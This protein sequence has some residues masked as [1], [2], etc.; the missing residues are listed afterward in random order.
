MGPTHNRGEP[1]GSERQTPHTD[2]AYVGSFIEI[3]GVEKGKG[4]RKREKREERERETEMQREKD[5]EKKEE[6]VVRVSP[7]KGTGY[8]V[9]RVMCSVGPLGKGQVHL[10][11]NIQSLKVS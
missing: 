3:K 8:T 9:S 7:F 10:H 11:V 2:R 6:E 1:R 5:K 4:E